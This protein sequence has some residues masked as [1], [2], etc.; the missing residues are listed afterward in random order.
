MIGCNGVHGAVGEP[1][2]QRFTVFSCGQRRIHLKFRI[3]LNVFVDQR[4]MVRRDFASDGQ[5]ARLR[6]AHLLQ[7]GLRGKMCDMQARP[8][9]L[10]ELQVARDANGFR[11]R[12]H[13]A[14]AKP[15][16]SH[17]LPHDRPGS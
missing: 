15:R 5:P 14:Q 10:C 13:P 3:V 9:E 17:T 6:P 16:G 1:R 2:E 4:E 12:R 11:C 7:R 8:G